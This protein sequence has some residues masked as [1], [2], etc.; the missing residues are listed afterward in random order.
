MSY[1]TENKDLIRQYR[2]MGWQIDQT[3][4]GH[5]RWRSPTGAIVIDSQT[6]SDP[7]GR[8]NHIAR[9]KKCANPLPPRYN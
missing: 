5:M 7:R 6:R 4:G 1:Q 8:K 3:A 2:A 9:L